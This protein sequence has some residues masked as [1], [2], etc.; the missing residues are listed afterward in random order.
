MSDERAGLIR[1]A[2]M[3]ERRAWVLL[4][5]SPNCP[6]PPP[7]SVVMSPRARRENDCKNKT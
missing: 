2:A 3:D 4:P 7:L 1:G 5:R 6:S